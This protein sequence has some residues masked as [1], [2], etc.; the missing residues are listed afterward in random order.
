MFQAF[1]RRISTV[2]S[3]L[4]SRLRFSIII[5]IVAFKAHSQS[6]GI[7]SPAASGTYC[8]GASGISVVYTVSGTFSNSPAANVFSAQISDPVGSFG[9][10]PVTV[11]TISSTTNGTLSCAVDVYL[12]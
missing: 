11:G 7:T 5:I 9:G 10:T 8:A 4:G 12:H 6:I 3:S 1:Y 2:D